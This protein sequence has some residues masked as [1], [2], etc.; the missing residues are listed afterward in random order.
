MQTVRR[1]LRTWTT[2]FRAC[3]LKLHSDNE[4]V[5]AALAKRSIKG[6]GIRPLWR[7]AIHIAVHDIELHS[8]CIPTKENALPEALS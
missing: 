3:R 4:A 6:Q 8:L 5:L 2:E 7:I 1:A